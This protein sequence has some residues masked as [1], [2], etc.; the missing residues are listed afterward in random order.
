M[1]VGVI[2][3]GVIARFYLA[4]IEAVPG[5]RLGAVCDLDPAMLAPFDGTV[6]CFTDH[7]AMLAEAGLD[8][9]I[10][11]A[12]NDTHARL[13]LDVL[14]AGLPVCVE[15]PLA[16]TLDDGI[17]VDEMA[18]RR[19]VPL[20]TAF[21]RRYN[22]HVQALSA[23][24]ADAPPITGLTVRYLERIEEHVG[25]D[26]WYLDAA[27]CGG[28]CVADNGPNAFDLAE[29]FLGPLWLQDARIARD[30]VNTDRQAVLSVHGHAPGVIE[31]DWSFPGERKEIEVRLAD[32]T[33]RTIDLLAGY[34]E[35]KSSLRHEY[36][37]V[38]TAFGHAVRTHRRTDRGLATLALVDAAYQREGAARAR[39]WS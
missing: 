20:F 13:C 35:F 2:G 10:I 23:E 38:L 33:T 27:R 11:T 25:K 4:A 12:P 16:T 39:E 29:L 6:P 31:L 1:R 7:R 8:A 24:L 9:V 18:R 19:D 5:W 14:G 34:R 3:L 28:G 30:H 21:H 32:G 22:S 26:R 15:K 17:A 37:G 36:Q